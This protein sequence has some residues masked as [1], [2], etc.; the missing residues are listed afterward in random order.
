M[1][2]NRCLPFA[3]N[4]SWNGALGDR[5]ASSATGAIPCSI[6]A[7]ST[8]AA[9]SRAS[10]KRQVSGSI[11][12]TGSQV[13][14]IGAFTSDRET[15]GSPLTA[16]TDGDGG[17]DMRHA[18][19]R[20]ARLPDARSAARVGRR[21]RRSARPYKTRPGGRGYCWGGRDCAY[22]VPRSTHGVGWSS[23]NRSPEPT[24]SHPGIGRPRIST[25]LAVVVAT[26]HRTAADRHGPWRP[27][28]AAGGN[29]HVAG[30]EERKAAEHLLLSQIGSTGTDG[31]GVRRIRLISTT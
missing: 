1:A 12:L 17:A 23:V 24:C 16:I 3:W 26:R 25:R 4:V 15:N 22:P 31:S 29:R 18:S 19:S 8:H 10:C 27:W 20:Y 5:S 14:R 30:D 9:R 11:P 13:R 2:T 21:S 28:L 6:R 7:A